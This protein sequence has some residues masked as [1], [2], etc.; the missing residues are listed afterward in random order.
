MSHNSINLP[1]IKEA[2]TRIRS[3]IPLTPLTFSA[4]LSERLKLEVY[5]KWENKQLSGSFKERGAINFLV[6]LSPDAKKR[7][8]CAASGGNHALALSLHSAKLEIPCTIVMPI[9]AP[10]VKVEA[11]KKTGAR[12]LLQGTTIDDA[13]TIARE[14]STKENLTYAPPFDHHD[15]ICGQ[16]SCGV[17]ILDQLSD[18][19]AV[20][21]PVGGGGLISGIATAIKSV[22]PNIYI[23]GAQSEW[24]VQHATSAPGPTPSKPLNR[25]TIADGIALKR[26]GEIP[27]EIIS[28]LVDKIEVVDE[29]QIASG[30]ITFLEAEKTVVEGSGAAGLA[31]LQK[32]KLPAHVKRVVVVVSGS[33]IDANLLSMLIERNLVRRGRW[34]PLALSVPD[35]PG[36]LHAVT[37]IIAAQGANVLH[38]R[39]DRYATTLGMVDI[40]FLLE[41]KDADHAKRIKQELMAAGV[42]VLDQAQKQEFAL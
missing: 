40:M 23:L 10:L 22:R 30:I 7:G 11:T 41:V 8:V 13:I 42:H 31:A 37:G 2:T 27:K 4:A 12:V 3:R 25:G 38:V 14:I 39:H 9:Y 34:L 36:S 29:E 5:C 17:E 21:V 33:N 6:K 32:C 26:L 18:F 19:D 20:V 15:I 16:G 35:R 24:A 1:E 28:K